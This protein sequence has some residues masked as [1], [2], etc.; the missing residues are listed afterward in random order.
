MLANLPRRL[1]AVYLADLEIV[2]RLKKST[3]TVPNDNVIVGQKNAHHRCSNR[4]DAAPTRIGCR[5]TTTLFPGLERIAIA[6]VH[7]DGSVVDRNKQE[8]PRFL[9][10]LEPP[11]L[12]IAVIQRRN[13]AL[14]FSAKQRPM[15]EKR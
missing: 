6:S 11:V 9:A 3:Q 14:W 12:L 4:R 13:R 1:D 8:Y 15:G 7:S 10:R 5:A 2:V